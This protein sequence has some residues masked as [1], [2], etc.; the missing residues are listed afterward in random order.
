[1]TA[2]R[3]AAFFAGQAVM[4]CGVAGCVSIVGARL[5][6]G[7]EHGAGD[8]PLLQ[9]GAGKRYRHANVLDWQGKYN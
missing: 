4:R 2:A 9:L 1:M 8:P 7:V 5:L 6:S 3:F